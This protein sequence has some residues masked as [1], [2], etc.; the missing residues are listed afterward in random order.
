MQA[1]CLRLADSALLPCLNVL[2]LGGN[3][4]TSHDTWLASVDAVTALRSSLSVLWE[5]K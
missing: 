4:V 3:T 1:L 2:S 5:N